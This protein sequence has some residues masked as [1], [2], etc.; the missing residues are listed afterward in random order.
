MKISIPLTLCLLLLSIAFV[1]AQHRFSV[2]LTASPAYGHT[3]ARL[4]YLL[5]T[6]TGQLEPAVFS[7]DISSVGYT[8]GAMAH[9][10]F[11]PSLSVSTGFWYNRLG[12]NGIFPFAPGPIP[13]RIIHRAIQVPLLLNY[14]SSQRRLSPYFSA[15]LL[16]D[17]RRP[18]IFRPESGSGQS[19]ARVLAGKQD[20]FRPVLG[21]GISYRINQHVSLL[22]QPLLIWQFRPNK[23]YAHFVSYQINAQTQLVYTF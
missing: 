6:G 2:A 7:S 15:G 17:V 10:A 21:A 12:T 16:V 13:A 22:V 1:S 19:D 3:S 23:D 4:N 14:R 18:T 20:D 9:Y 5:P 8:L 11:T